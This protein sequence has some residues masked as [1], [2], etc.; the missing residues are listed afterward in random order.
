MKNFNDFINIENEI[1]NELN[2]GL[3]SWLGGMMKKL[4]GF[5]RKVKGGKQIQQI[6]DDGLASA[7]ASFQKQ[8]GVELN[9]KSEAESTSETK[10]KSQVESISNRLLDFDG[11]VINEEAEVAEV[12]VGQDTDTKEESET[13]TPETSGQDTDEETPDSKMD[14]N[15]LTK[16]A[17]VLQKVL[18]LEKKKTL[19]K[20]NQVL[21]KMGGKEKNRKLAGIISMKMLEFDIAFEE[22]SI[23]YIEKSGDKAAI[24][25]LTQKKKELI[26]KQKQLKKTSEDLMKGNAEEIE[27]DGEKFTLNVPYRY[28]TEKGI[29]TIKISGK[30]EEQGKVTANYVSDKFGGIE[31]QSFQVANIEKTDDFNPV[32]NDTYKY[33]SK[34]A[35]KI[36]KVKVVDVKNNGLIKVKS[37][38]NEFSVPVGSLTSKVDTQPQPQVETP[39]G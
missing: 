35:N 8:A 31:S 23:K 15:S 3:L 4:T 30:S 34:S 18:G 5:I 28:K 13:D 22:A 37:G 24:A 7:T 27:V 2:E 36:I 26:Q 38:E 14:A 20:M 17:A 21:D 11:F 33:F 12:E 19:L 32:V 9:L 29:K 25:K 1:E 6:Y 16:K 39:Q 10:V